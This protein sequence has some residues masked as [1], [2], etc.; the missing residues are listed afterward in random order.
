MS[1]TVGVTSDALQATANVTASVAETVSVETLL[2]PLAGETPAG[3]NVQYSGL[4]DEVREARRNEEIL[5]QGEWKRE[6]KVADWDKVETLTSDALATKTKDLQIA[7][8]LA[9]ALTKNHG[10]AGARDGLKIARG[11]LENFWDTLYPEID[12]GDLEGRANNLAWLDKQVALALKEVPIVQ[13]AEAFSYLDFED[14]QKFDI[15][16]NIESLDST[17][18]E[19][20]AA[21]RE[22]ATTE[23][24][25]TTEDW[26]KAKAA[27]R[28]AFY[29]TTLLTL[30]E[31]W[32]E[33]G[34]LDR[35]M[36]EKLAKETPGLG[37]LKK[38]LEDVRALVERITKEKRVSEPDAIELS[39]SADASANGDA[40]VLQT[41]AAL[42]VGGAI[43]SRQEAL[44]RLGEIADFFRQTEP[45]SPVSYLVQRAVRWGQMPLE[46]WLQDVIKD[47]A[48]M[49][50]LR[51]TL[52]LNLDGAGDNVS[53][54]GSSSTSSSSE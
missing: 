25:T 29:E 16:E 31:T 15:P 36:D 13:V 19:R 28:R 9:E 30:N 37:A 17:E 38:S 33:F 6:T 22:Q 10:F 41:G 27:S 12:E 32:E 5:E 11:L 51:D 46:N 35:V 44:R 50:L 21:L 49:S 24:R 52:G 43:R 2:A 3:E 34:Q 48:V 4:H 14:A 54:T 42:G 8:W 18:Q 47:D 20:L 45:H 39:A 40:E 53:S 1:A 7:A 26:R 23:G